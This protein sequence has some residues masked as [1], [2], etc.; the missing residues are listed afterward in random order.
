M[1][2]G[3]IIQRLTLVNAE[4]SSVALDFYIPFLA[5][6]V[7]F[8]ITFIPLILYLFYL[9]RKTNIFNRYLNSL[10]L[11]VVLSDIIYIFFPTKVIRPF[12][13]KDGFFQFLVNFVYVSDFPNNALPSQHV[14][15]SAIAI[16][17][18]LITKHYFLALW[19]VFI[20]LST[21]FIKQHFILDVLLAILFSIL[22]LIFVESETK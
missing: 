6:F 16:Y 19:F 14:G 17:Y 12:V 5:G 8:Y 2:L 4:P 1:G 7:V 10:F 9:F 21:I 20:I 3:K 18:L 15:M 22:I 13:A 11:F